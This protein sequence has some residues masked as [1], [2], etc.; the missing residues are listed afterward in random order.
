[1]I[2]GDQREAAKTGLPLVALALRLCKAQ[3]RGVRG[4]LH[5]CD[6]P[7]TVARRCH[8]NVFVVSDRIGYFNTMKR[9]EDTYEP[10]SPRP[11]QY[12][13]R[14]FFWLM[15]AVALALTY[16]RSFG[17][18]II[19]QAVIAMIGSAVVAVCVGWPFKRIAD[20]LYWSVLGTVFAFMSA[21]GVV[22]YHLAWAAVGAVSGAAVGCVAAGRPVRSMLAGGTAGG[23]VLGVYALVPYWPSGQLILFDVIGAVVIGAMF[24][25]LVE[26]FFWLEARTKLPRYVSATVLMLSVCVGNLL[27]QHFVP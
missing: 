3:S 26:I 6:R 2:E 20:S 4:P 9:N 13:T 12:G 11:F 19:V 8:N 21:V 18:D 22:D 5:N 25:A 17:R 15:V 10:P 24:G 23:I 27:A 7:G 1:M 16:L 14:S